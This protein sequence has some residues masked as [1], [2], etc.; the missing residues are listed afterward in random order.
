[1]CKRWRK[2]SHTYWERTWLSDMDCQTTSTI[3]SLAEEMKTLFADIPEAIITYQEV[4][5]KIEILT[6]A[7]VLLPA[8]DIPDEFKDQEDE[9]DGENEERITFLK[10]LNLSRCK[11]RYGEITD[12]Y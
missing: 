8:F 6:L 3:L 4:V 10:H 7:D 5:D 2:A 9:E 1:M 12:S 11:K